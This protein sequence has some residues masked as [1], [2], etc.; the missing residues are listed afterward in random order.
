MVLPRSELFLQ[1]TSAA[2][3]ECEIW[4]AGCPECLPRILHGSSVDRDPGRKQSD[5]QPDPERW[6]M[7]WGKLQHSPGCSNTD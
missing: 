5:L 4:L 3:P 2:V 6:V 1:W 7:F